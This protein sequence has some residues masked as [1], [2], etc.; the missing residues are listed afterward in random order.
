MRI[1]AR[2]GESHLVKHQQGCWRGRQ[3]RP[4]AVI[5]A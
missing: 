2:K 5:G 1:S 4:P 3:H